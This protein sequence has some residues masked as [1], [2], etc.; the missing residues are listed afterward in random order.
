M[1]KPLSKQERA[2]KT[3]RQIEMVDAAL[4]RQ[5]PDLPEEDV[6]REVALVSKDLIAH[7]HFTDHVAV[8]TGRLV[9]ENFD[10]AAE[11]AE[12]EAAAPSP[13]GDA[14]EPNEAAS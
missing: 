11:V 1:I 14:P 13:G 2:A 10:A 4:V 9:A 7:A 5:F 8:L 12:E 3:E 6:H